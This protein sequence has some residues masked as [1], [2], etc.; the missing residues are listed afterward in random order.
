MNMAAEKDQVVIHVENP[1]LLRPGFDW[2]TNVWKRR[3]PRR[4]QVAQLTKP[5]LTSTD[6]DRIMEVR[7]D[8]G[9]GFICLLSLKQAATR[10]IQDIQTFSHVV[11]SHH[12]CRR[13]ILFV[14]SG[15]G[16]RP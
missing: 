7:L 3:T 13:V 15:V 8:P 14:T 16:Y 9:K 11:Q 1:D 6:V 12:V 10:Y 2:N 5:H 4:S